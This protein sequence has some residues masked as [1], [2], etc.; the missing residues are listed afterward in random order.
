MDGK[1][2]QGPNHHLQ[3]ATLK[4]KDWS[5]R[6]PQKSGVT[7]GSAEAQTVPIPLVPVA[8]VMLLLNKY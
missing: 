3:I 6:T 5:T 4:T 2:I 8:T 7:S 1:T